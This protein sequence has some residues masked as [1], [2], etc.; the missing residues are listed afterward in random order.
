LI[1]TTK[2]KETRNNILT[3][4]IFKSLIDTFGKQ[5]LIVLT[6]CN[7]PKVGIKLLKISHVRMLFLVSLLFVAVINPYSVFK[8]LIF[9][10]SSV[11]LNILYVNVQINC[12]YLSLHEGG[13]NT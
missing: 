12:A 6:Y 8:L 9:K 4:D 10:Y 5:S 2:S 13:L 7:G 11:Y 3:S 1:T